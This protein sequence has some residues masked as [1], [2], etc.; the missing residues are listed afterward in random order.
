MSELRPPSY[1]YTQNDTC[2]TYETPLYSWY[3]FG[4]KWVNVMDDDKT[5]NERL[6][7]LREAHGYSLRA[8]AKE[9]GKSANTVLRWE[10]G[11]SDP[12]RNDIVKLA[13]FYNQEPTWL[14]WGT[15]PRDTDPKTKKLISKLPLLSDEQLK[16][17][18]TLVNLLL[19]GKRE[20]G[21]NGGNKP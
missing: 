10:T 21:T 17:V 16:A 14:Q 19:D 4:D 18:D 20:N 13:K 15:R 7:L 1:D 12:S 2:H 5:V 11:D 8:V 3:A 6:A 9:V